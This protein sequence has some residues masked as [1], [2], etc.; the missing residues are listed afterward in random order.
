M[1]VGWLVV[2]NRDVDFCSCIVIVA[3]MVLHMPSILVREM[4]YCFP[5]S[6]DDCQV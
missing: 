2:K 6:Q 1:L 3:M 5:A 4:G